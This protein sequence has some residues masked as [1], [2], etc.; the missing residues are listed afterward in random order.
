MGR[1][2]YYDPAIH[3]KHHVSA[4]RLTKEWMIERAYWGGVSDAL[5]SYL[6]RG[7]GVWWAARTFLWSVRTAL[8]NPR[9]MSRLIRRTDD[10]MVARCE[11]SHRLGSIVGGCR[12]VRLAVLRSER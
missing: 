11:A 1:P 10:D 3:V 7:G 6:H 8:L 4:A 12:A 2:V 5:L 9:V